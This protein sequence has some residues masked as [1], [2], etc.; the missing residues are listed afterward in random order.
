MLWLAD[1]T[2]FIIDVQYAAMISTLQNKLGFRKGAFPRQF[3]L[4]FWGMLV[5]TIGSSMVWPFLVVYVS[6]KLAMP[7]TSVASLITLSSACGLIASLTGG[8]V[9]DRLGRKW[10]MVV[11]LLLNGAGYLLMSQAQSYL[12]FA[13]IMALNGTVNPLYR[14]AADAMMADLIPAPQRPE[15]YSL[16]RMANNLG[17]SIGPALGGFLAAVS[18][19]ITFSIAAAG[20]AGFSLMVALF[21][22]ETMPQRG[23]AGAAEMPRE[24]FGGYGKVLSN[25]PFS[26]MV[27]VFAMVQ[28]CA[29]LIWMLLAVY[30]K[31]YYGVNE[32]QYGWIPTTNAVMVVLFQFGVTQVTRRFKPLPVMA[33]G[34]FFYAIA[35]FSVAMGTGFWWFWGTMVVMTVGEL[36]LVPTVSTYTAN[37]APPE[38]RARYMSLSG[39]TWQVASGI[40]PVFGGVLSDHFGPRTIWLGG[41]FVGVL[42]VA[43]FLLL[44][45]AFRSRVRPAVAAQNAE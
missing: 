35:T 3:W 33:V 37:L 6:G 7:L 42:S 11:S 12:A 25:L 13:V 10:V 31:T 44:E 4:M 38:Q 24:R 27:F 9:I 21:A 15:A 20:L 32:S 5:S 41:G 28:V 1:S 30:S 19:S 14:V 34:A 8:P 45:R 40:G 22:I 39:L 2:L 17:I 29:S 23:H 43:G 18:Y 16:L 26:G 36:A